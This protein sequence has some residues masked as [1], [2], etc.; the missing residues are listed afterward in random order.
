MSRRRRTIR[1]IE[2]A[3]VT[4]SCNP[5]RPTRTGDADEE[6][7]VL[8]VCPPVEV[9]RRW[10]ERADIKKGRPSGRSTEGTPWRRRRSHRSRSI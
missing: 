6:G 1:A 9:L 7:R 10:L 2:I 5:P 4:L 3:H 8:L